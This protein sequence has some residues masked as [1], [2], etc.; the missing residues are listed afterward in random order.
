MLQVVSFNFAINGGKIDAGN[1]SG[2]GAVSLGGFQNGSDMSPL[3]FIQGQQ[4]IVFSFFSVRL[5]QGDTDGFQVQLVA[6]RHPR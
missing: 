6:V 3:H 1:F 4:R 2:P 5:R